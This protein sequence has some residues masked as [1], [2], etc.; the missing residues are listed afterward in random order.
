MGE[1]VPEFM[2]QSFRPNVTEDS[3]DSSADTEVSAR[4]ADVT[5][6]PAVAEDATVPAPA[7]KTRTR[8]RKPKV[9]P[10]TEPTAG[11]APDAVVEPAAETPAPDAT[12]AEKPKRTRRKKVEPADGAPAESVMPTDATDAPAKPKR[13]RRKKTTEDAEA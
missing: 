9:T 7:K 1:H 8:S 2:L 13:T 12:V 10:A 5:A 3:T 6:A 11:T 4:A